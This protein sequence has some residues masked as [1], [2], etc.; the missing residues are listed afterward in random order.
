MTRGPFRKPDAVKKLE[1]NPRHEKL[2]GELPSPGT[3]QRPKRLP[4]EA[5]WLWDLVAQPWVG[6]LDT[7]Q[8]ITLCET[9]VLLRAAAKAALKDPLDKNTRC[10]YVAYKSEFDKLAARFA[11]TPSDRAKIRVPEPPKQDEDDKFFG[12]VG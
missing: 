6:E 2:G 10:A 8:L 11:M 3:P 12:V 9:W 5:A 1:G 7:A 4:K